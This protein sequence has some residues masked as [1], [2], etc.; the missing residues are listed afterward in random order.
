MPTYQVGDHVVDHP[1]LFACRKHKTIL[2][3][4]RSFVDELVA[5][6]PDLQPQNLTEVAAGS[7]DGDDEAFRLSEYLV[8][9]RVVIFNPRKIE[10]H[11]ALPYFVVLI[12]RKFFGI[13]SSY[14]RRR[15]FDGCFDCAEENDPASDAAFPDY[16]PKPKPA[17]APRPAAP[18]APPAKSGTVP[19]V[20]KPATGAPPPGQKA[21]TQRQPRPQQGAPQQGSPPQSAPQQA[22]QAPPAKKPGTQPPPTKSI[23]KRPGE[24]KFDIPPPPV[25]DH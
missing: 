9:A 21:P 10:G 13:P 2:K 8:P 23:P 11:G 3:L 22:P 18:A 12:D 4:N 1:P 17:P 7:L 16:K 6:A 14:L 15:A 24:P 5:W 25:G 20:A 19:A